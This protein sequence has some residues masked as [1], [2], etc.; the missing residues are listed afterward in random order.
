MQKTV[1]VA[2]MQ[3]GEGRGRR[4]TCLL[5]FL[6]SARSL[7]LS[8][9]GAARTLRMQRNPGQRLCPLDSAA[10]HPGYG[11]RNL[12]PRAKGRGTGVKA[13]YLKQ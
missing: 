5:F 7:Y 2:W 1:G 3:L 6:G 11:S 10:L 4:R 13:R 12:G 8:P 9:A